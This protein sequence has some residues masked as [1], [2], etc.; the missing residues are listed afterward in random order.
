MAFLDQNFQKNITINKD[1]LIAT[2]SC[3]RH[4]KLVH[5]YNDS[6]SELSENA[7]YKLTDFGQIVFDHFYYL[8]E[9]QPFYEH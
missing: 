6:D 5:C 7:L 9:N 8:K 2:L 1:T 3:L 4:Y